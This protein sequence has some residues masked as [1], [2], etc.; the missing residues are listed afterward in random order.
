MNPDLNKLHP[1]PFEKLASLKQGLTPPAELAPI[2][3]SIGEPKHAAPGFVIEAMQ[4]A[5]DG[6]SRYPLTRGQLD[7]RIAIVEWLTR[8]FRLPANSL[9]PERH[10]LPVT[11][12]REALFA[13]AQAVVDRQQNACVL[14]PNPFYQIYEGAALLAGAEPVYLNTVAENHFIP[15]FDR[16]S[17]TT[18][19]RCQLLYLCSPG[20][21]T[22][23]VIDTASL[24]RLIGLA[25]Q[26]DFI[27][28]SDECYS[29]IYFDEQ[30]PPVGLLQAAAEAGHEDYRRCVVFHS[31]SKRSNLPGLRS[32][33]VAGDA[34][35]L[36]R[37][38]KY[39]TYHGCAMPPHHQVASMQAWQDESHVVVNR[40]QYRA[41]FDAVLEILQ[42]VLQVERPTAGFYLWPQTPLDDTTFT[43]QLYARQNVTVL[44]GSYL[45]RELDGVNPG[46]QRVRMAL[47]AEFDECIEAAKRIRTYLESIN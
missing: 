43:Q 1:Y 29:E 41:K 23:A 9:D 8:R 42:P 14:M 25:E 7:L 16:V 36:A 38:L 3:L 27:I 5:L 19:Q 24:Q 13:F 35:V 12:T 10:V 15:D 39:R 40:H 2:A 33:F 26:Y 17:A 31:L 44:P 46:Y 30:Q 32:G 45:S 11:G 4:A 34:D 21:P 37:F 18:W 20:N 22:G 47:V 28:A 6:L